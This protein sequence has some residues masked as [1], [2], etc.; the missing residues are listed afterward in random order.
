MTALL[1]F[2]ATAAGKWIVGALGVVV[3]IIAAWLKGRLSGAKAER[4]K[5]AASEVKARDV[6]DEVQSDVGAM[7]ADHIRA[8][9][10]KRAK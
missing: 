4:A 1:A 3:A 7:S 6:A 2:F 9:L 10:A 5:Q 8:E